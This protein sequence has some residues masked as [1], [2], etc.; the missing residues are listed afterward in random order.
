MSKVKNLIAGAA[1]AIALNV[2]HETLK[3][4]SDDVPRVDLLGEDAVQKVLK[5]FG[6]S[7]PDKASLYKT[8]LA[9]DL[10]SNTLYYSLIGAGNQ[11]YLWPKAVFLGL[12][13]GIGAVKLPEPMGLDPEPVTKT[14]QVKVLTVGYYIFGAIVTGL[15][16]NLL[17]KK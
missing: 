2:L 5:Y 7:V 4:E 10:I 8:T 3:K 16:L 6:S 11:K 1:G 14:D 17:N 9:G 15:V 13:A 12:T